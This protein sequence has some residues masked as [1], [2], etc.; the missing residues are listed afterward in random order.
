MYDISGLCIDYDNIAFA[1]F[2]LNNKFI[3]SEI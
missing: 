3:G 2:L 1:S